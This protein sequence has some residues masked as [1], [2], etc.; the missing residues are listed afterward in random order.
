MSFL[1]RVLT[2]LLLLLSG[3][4]ATG[5]LNAY[6]YVV[7]PKQFEAF[8]EP[9]QYHT[10]T[11]IKYLLTEAGFTAYYEGEVPETSGDLCDGLR[12]RLLDESSMFR[13][14]TIL[15]FEDCRDKEVYRT[16]EGSSR[17]KDLR[18]GYGE[19]IETAFRSIANLGYHYEPGTDT[20]GPVVLDFDGDVR[21]PQDDGHAGKSTDG[22][23]ADPVLVQEAS[24][25]QQKYKNQSPQPS[26]IQKAPPLKNAVVSEKVASQ[27]SEPWFAQPIANGYQL[28][29]RTPAIR[30]RLYSSSRPDVFIAENDE[31][32]GVVYEQD[33][34]WYFEFYQEGKK[35]VMELDIRF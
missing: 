31:V 24:P 32:N 6:R 4:T 33:E 23:L 21:Q 1:R 3:A 11:L 28:V 22:P 20:A 16:P 26:D 25:E 12:L 7:V 34:H 17:E 18:E 8:K 9:N 2:L 5:Q 10:S 35:V 13:T 30:L 15:I 19:A 27:S 29:D 14:R